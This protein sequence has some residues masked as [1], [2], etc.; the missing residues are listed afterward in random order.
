MRPQHK[1]ASSGLT[2]AAVAFI[3]KI[4]CSDVMKAV[5]FL[6]H[7]R[8]FFSLFKDK[9]RQCHTT[10]V[11]YSTLSLMNPFCFCVAGSRSAA[12]GKRLTCRNVLKRRPGEI[13]S[14]SICH[15][16]EGIGSMSSVNT[17]YPSS[18][19]TS[20]PMGAESVTTVSFSVV[21]ICLTRRPASLG[22][23]SA[24]SS[25]CRSCCSN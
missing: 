3:R 18:P 24:F 6:S 11:S 10:Q 4:F 12:E 25:P 22:D 14:K 17:L 5:F 23:C 2:G 13:L 8:P 21:N 1:K 20:K 9:R 7:S 15:I 19:S 16:R